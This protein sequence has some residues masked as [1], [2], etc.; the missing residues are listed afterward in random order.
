M[1]FR[2][3]DALQHATPLLQSLAPASAYARHA[4]PARAAANRGKSTPPPPA[5]DVL[6]TNNFANANPWHLFFDGPSS[7]ELS[8][9]HKCLAF[10]NIADLMYQ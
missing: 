10:S 6:L 1:Y 8:S 9:K 2:G 4:L 7:E 5:F 3:K